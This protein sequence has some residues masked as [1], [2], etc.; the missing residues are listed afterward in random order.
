MFFFQFRDFEENF[1]YFF[2]FKMKFGMICFS[3]LEIIGIRSDMQFYNSRLGN[4]SATSACYCTSEGICRASCNSA[5]AQSAFQFRAAPSLLDGWV[6]PIITYARKSRCTIL[7]R[8][9]ITARVKCQ[10]ALVNIGACVP[11]TMVAK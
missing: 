5:R 10:V 3:I 4:K 11:C 9:T 8:C 1:Y 6:K 7:A 2:N